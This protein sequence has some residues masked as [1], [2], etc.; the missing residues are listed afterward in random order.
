MS[1]TFTRPFERSM[2]TSRL[3]GDVVKVDQLN[4]ATIRWLT[5]ALY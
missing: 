3:H 4:A 1:R 5:A 2:M